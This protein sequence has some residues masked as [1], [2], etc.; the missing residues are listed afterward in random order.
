M[1]LDQETSPLDPDIS[2][3]LSLGL[4]AKVVP[5]TLVDE[6]L[7]MTSRTSRRIRLLPARDVVYLVMAM[8]L[9]QAPPLPE[10]ARIF[11]ESSR[12]LAGRPPSPRFPGKAALSQARSKL[13][14]EPMRLIADQVLRPIAIPGSP[15]CWRD[16]KRLMS[17]DET[18]F[19]MP[20]ERENVSYFGRQDVSIGLAAIPQAKVLALVETGTRVVAAA[21]IAPC[22]TSGRAMARKLI[23]RGK[24][25]KDMLLLAGDNLL[26]DGLWAAAEDTG[27]KLV[28]RAGSGIDLPAI[29]VLPDGSFISLM[30]DGQAESRRVRVID[31]ELLEENPAPGARRAVLESHRLI[32]N[33][34]DHES[35]PLEELATLHHERWEVENLYEEFNNGPRGAYAILR[36][37]TPDLVIQELWGLL[38]VHFALRGLMAELTWRFKPDPDGSSLKDGRRGTRP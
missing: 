28:W 12:R 4:L 5:E 13:G 17:M 14:S 7:A 36:G 34:F 24:L 18:C 15:G 31:Y 32:T 20:Y 27:A 21:E 38:L 19:A 2:R 23:E 37:K 3:P 1:I 35:A 6:A 9:F 22:G 11:S 29:E 30:R 10:I 26:G 8:S 25:T 16:G 33:V